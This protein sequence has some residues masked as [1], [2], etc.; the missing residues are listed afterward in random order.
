MDRVEDTPSDTPSDTSSDTPTTTP[1]SPKDS[2]IPKSTDTPTDTPTDKPT[3]V[4]K[5]KTTVSVPLEKK[6]DF[7]DVPLPT[8]EAKEA[9][10]K[11]SVMSCCVEYGSGMTTM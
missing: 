10:R 3:E 2:D 11:K 5:V 4:K 8:K 1:E 6:V 7:K 9:S